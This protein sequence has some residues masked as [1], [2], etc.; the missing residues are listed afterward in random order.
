MFMILSHQKKTKL[1]LY[2]CLIQKLYKKNNTQTKKN[3]DLEMGKYMWES[4]ASALNGVKYSYY[5]NKFDQMAHSVVKYPPAN[6]GDIGDAG[7]I[8]GSGRF[9]GE[10]N[11]NP[12]QYFF[13]PGESPWKEEPG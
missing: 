13:L 4:Q 3:T 6:A 11:D 12:L 8:P 2:R 10:E 5:S 9:L 7:S 1:F